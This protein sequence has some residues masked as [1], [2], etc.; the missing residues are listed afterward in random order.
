MNELIVLVKSFFRNA[1]Y[2]IRF[3]I[4]DLKQF[5]GLTE[6]VRG[7]NIRVKVLSKNSPKTVKTRD[8]KYHKVVNIKVTNRIG[9]II[10]SLW[11]EMVD[12]L[13][14]DYLVDIENGYINTFK[15]ELRPECW[16]IWI[17]I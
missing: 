4:N 14:D 5:N 13:K 17:L 11:D 12:L 10:L 15:G 8:D 3:K 1:S 9:Q 7:I 16:Q 2:F 6:N